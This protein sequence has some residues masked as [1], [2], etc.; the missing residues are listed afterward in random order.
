MGRKERLKKKALAH[1]E[2]PTAG[3]KVDSQGDADMSGSGMED[4][5][6]HAA[7][8]GEAKRRRKRR[9]RSVKE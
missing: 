5:R 8:D 3:A 1:G 4:T 2:S 6:T 7:E 9:K